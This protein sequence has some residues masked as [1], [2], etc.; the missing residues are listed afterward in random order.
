MPCIRSN[1]HKLQVSGVQH[2]SSNSPSWPSRSR[3][4]APP[5]NTHNH[6]ALSPRANL[7]N[8][9]PRMLGLRGAPR[10][11]VAAA[12]SQNQTLEGVLALHHTCLRH[13]CPRHTCPRHTC[14]R[15]TC[16]RHTC[17]RGIVRAA[18]RCWEE[19]EGN[20]VCRQCWRCAAGAS[21][22]RSWCQ[23]PSQLVPT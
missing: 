19:S 16:L 11:L 17:P 1:T 9:S 23:P 6:L 5:Y 10:R 22:G 21:L 7:R 8:I 20:A 2:T 4:R 14:L 18:A 3:C 12:R 15:H 13:T